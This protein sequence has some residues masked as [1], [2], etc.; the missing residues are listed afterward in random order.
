MWYVW[1]TGADRVLVGKPAGRSPLERSR[2]RWE[3]IKMDL[4]EV[5][6]G[7]HGLGKS[8]SGQGQVADSCACG[9]EPSASIKYGAFLE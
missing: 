6:W 7:G 9:N 2:H 5:G 4:T 1:W 3:D 8:G